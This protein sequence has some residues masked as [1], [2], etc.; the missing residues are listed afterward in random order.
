MSKHHGHNFL[1]ISG[2]GNSHLRNLVHASSISETKEAKK[3]RLKIEQ[4]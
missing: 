3:L 1:R 4:N 2:S